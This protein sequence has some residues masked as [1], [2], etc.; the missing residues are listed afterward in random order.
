MEKLAGWLLRSLR[1]GQCPRRGEVGW[2]LP[3]AGGQSLA[4]GHCW[5][6]RCP[7]VQVQGARGTQLGSANL[8]A[9]NIRRKHNRAHRFPHLRTHTHTLS[10]SLVHPDEGNEDPEVEAC[11]PI[12]SVFG[13]TDFCFPF[14]RL[15]VL[16]TIPP[17]PAKTPTIL[18]IS[19]FSKN[20]TEHKQERGEGGEKKERKKKKKTTKEFA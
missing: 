12:Y 1:T 18:F 13:G 19:Y 14:S 3:Q 6:T 16:P 5:D 15:G 17:A 7:T 2:G 4:A 20:K 11:P 10:L 9:V 8:S